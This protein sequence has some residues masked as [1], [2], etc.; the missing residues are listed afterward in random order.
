MD[1]LLNNLTKEELI[2]VI[3]NMHDTINDWGGYGF[4]NDEREVL[5]EIGSECVEYC[6]SRN[7]FIIY[8]ILTKIKNNV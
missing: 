8:D 3:A 4:N 6:S 2:K 5:N 1:N 7:D